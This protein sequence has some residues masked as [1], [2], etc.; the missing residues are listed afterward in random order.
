[1]SITRRKFMKY[2]GSG[3]LAVGLSQ[4]YIPKL[5]KVL[6]AAAA[7]E[8]PVIWLQGSGCAGCSVSLLNTVH[9]SIAEVLLKIIS[10][11][12]H[13]NV[14]AACGDLAISAM[15]KA[16]KDNAGKF[17]LI[18]EGAIPTAEGGM[19]ATTGERDGKPVTI[20]KRVTELGGA[21]S[22][23]VAVGT[24]ACYGGI[25]AGSPNP[26]GAK[27]VGEV[28]GKTVL[29]IP[30]CPPHP[31]WMVGSLVHVLRYG[32]PALDED[33]RPKLFYGKNIHENCPSYSYYN[34]EIMAGKLSEEGCLSELG[35][36]GPMAYA[37][38]PTRRWNNGVNW[39]IGAKAP[40]IGCVEK[41]FPDELAPMY[42]QLPATKLPKRVAMPEKKEEIKVG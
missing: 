32:L 38:C 11:K 12:F 8:P 10:V 3:A 41:D 5:M 14:M 31:D 15:E 36:K 29:N 19:Y 17:I 40:C 25:P 22:A 1:M 2:C 37:D 18:V 4:F 42:T 39:C 21:A 9:P 7:G 34:N 6:E 24:C 26:T 13:P 33:G 16:A 20:L 23:I 28:L 27:G 35:C 30:G